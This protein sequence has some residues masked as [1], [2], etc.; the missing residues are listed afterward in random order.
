VDRDPVV[1]AHA[2]A[3]L[4]RDENT[5]AVP[6]DLR[7]PA[8]IL[9][10]PDVRAHLDTDRPVAVLLLAVLHFVIAD[11]EAARIVTT[12][13]ERLVPGSYL[14]VS[15]VADLSTTSEC[16]DRSEALAAR[17]AA[18]TRRAADLYATVAAPFT[19]RSPG[20]IAS[21]FEGLD[22]VPPGLVPAHTWRPGSGRPGPPVPVLA[23]VARLPEPTQATDTTTRAAP[24]EDHDADPT[25]APAPGPVPAAG[26]SEGAS[27]GG[28][29]ERR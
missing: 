24:D 1:L 11:D 12:V 2:R 9:A 26:V 5:L 29:G 27:A 10:D 13:R 7:D 16:P 20:Q 18:A 14:A 3:L 22:V 8:A 23:G 25:P 21:W 28:P 17:R 6:G 4:A 19:L 15:H